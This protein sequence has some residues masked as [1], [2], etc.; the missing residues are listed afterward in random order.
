MKIILLAGHEHSSQ[1][2]ALKTFQNKLWI[3]SYLEILLKRAYE[4]IVVLGDQH[5]EAILGSSQYLAKCD[6][7]FDTHGANTTLMTNLRAGLYSVQ[8]HALALPLSEKLPEP[9]CLQNLTTHYFKNYNQTQHLIKSYY[10]NLGQLTPGF[11]VFITPI[12][13]KLI[14]A[15]K[16]ITHIHDPQIIYSPAPIIENKMRDPLLSV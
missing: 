15:N 11:P 3:D 12:G 10:L 8:H 5:A 2:L 6:L 16:A 9:Q 13:K 1:S 7:V 4:I 14:L